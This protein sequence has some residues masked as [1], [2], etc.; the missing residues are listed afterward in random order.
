MQQQ[1]LPAWLSHTE[2]F[3]QPSMA[4]SSWTPL[5]LILGLA[6]RA[7]GCPTQSKQLNMETSSVCLQ[8]GILV[9]LMSHNTRPVAGPGC[10]PGSPVPGYTGK[11]WWLW[12]HGSAGPPGSLLRVRGWRMAPGQPWFLCPSSLP[13][14]LFFSPEKSDFPGSETA[15]GEFGARG[16][17]D[18]VGDLCVMGKYR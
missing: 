11:A 14:G 17:M 2:S 16:R 10:S 12:W 1:A 6:M 13:K 18:E 3:S 8:P 9:P 7:T 15:I 4:P 5:P